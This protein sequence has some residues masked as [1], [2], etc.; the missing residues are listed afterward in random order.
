MRI[1]NSFLINGLTIGRKSGILNRMNVNWQDEIW[2][3]FEWEVWKLNGFLQLV[4][5]LAAYN[6][7][8]F[9]GYVIAKVLWKVSGEYAYVDTALIRQRPGYAVI[10]VTGRDSEQDE[11]GFLQITLWKPKEQREVSKKHPEPDSVPCDHAQRRSRD[12]AD[13]TIR[14]TQEQVDHYLNLVQDT[15]P[16]HRGTNAIVPGLYALYELQSWKLLQDY[17]TEHASYEAAFR[18]PLPVGASCSVK[19]QDGSVQL[20]SADTTYFTIH[21]RVE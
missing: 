15:N 10:R 17:F 20:V 2:L 8:M 19:V 1:V 4:K 18:Q 6:D 3:T 9:D 12:Y 21:K 5:A 14:F 7:G 11:E 16:I 13:G